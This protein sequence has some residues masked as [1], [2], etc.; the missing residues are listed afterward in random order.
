MRSCDALV[1]V[2]TKNNSPGPLLSL[3]LF[4]PPVAHLES[5]CPLSSALLHHYFP[6]A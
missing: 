3:E 6:V 5:C 2:A 1:M 4:K